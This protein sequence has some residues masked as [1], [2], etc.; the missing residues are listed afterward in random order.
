MCPVT[1]ARERVPPWPGASKVHLD[2]ISIFSGRSRPGNLRP[3]GWASLSLSL[4]VTTHHKMGPTVKMNERRGN[5]KAGE[6]PVPFL[7]SHQ[8]SSWR[9]SFQ[10]HANQWRESYWATKRYGVRVEQYP[11]VQLR[12]RGRGQTPASPGGLIIDRGKGGGAPVEWQ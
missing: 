11:T 3:K 7:P 1:S 9:Y 2:Q 4:P 12:Y 5:K 10:P 6:P 8:V